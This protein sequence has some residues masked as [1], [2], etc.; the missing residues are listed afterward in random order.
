MAIEIANQKYLFRSGQFCQSTDTEAEM[1]AAMR[2]A[3][4]RY[5]VLKSEPDH[6]GISYNYIHDIE[7]VWWVM[8]WALFT[9]EKEGELLD[10]GDTVTRRTNREN[11]FYGPLKA[12]DRRDFFE[13]LEIYDNYTKCIPD[14][15]YSIKAA[16]DLVRKKII[17]EY[18]AKEVK[19]PQSIKYT[20]P[21]LHARFIAY[22]RHVNMESFAIVRMSPD[23]PE[24][25]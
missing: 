8:I 25:N 17:K 23:K 1:V 19:N 2:A 5:A 3:E 21:K 18:R 13:R 22:F 16:L 20:S 15:F 12:M 24:N 6:N 9:F 10:R 7:S 11:L 4:A 14:Y